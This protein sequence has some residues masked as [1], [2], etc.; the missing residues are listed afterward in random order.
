MLIVTNESENQVGRK[1]SPL[2][3][4]CGVTAQAAAAVSRRS[5]KAA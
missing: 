4:H 3:M 2:G 5:E 1:V